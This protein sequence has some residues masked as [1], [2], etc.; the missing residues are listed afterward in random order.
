MFDA[1][2][3][4]RHGCRE[5]A[6][7]GEVMR[8]RVTLA[9]MASTLLILLNGP[10]TAHA[11]AQ[12]PVAKWSFDE[13]DGAIARESV[14]GVDDKI[15]GIFKRVSGV[16]GGAL[17]LDG[18]TTGIVQAAANAPKL[19]TAFSIESWIAINTYSWNWIPIVDQRK[20]EEAG[21]LFGIDSFGHLGLQLAANGHWQSLTSTVPIPL[22][23]WTHVAAT[24]DSG[25]GLAIYLDG[26]LAGELLAPG[27]MIS[28]SD[29]DLLIGRLREA[30]VPAQWIHPKY[31]VWY[32]FDG[33]I[34]ELEIYN[35]SLTASEIAAEY[36]AVH[37]P[38]GEILPYPILPSG[39][40]GPGS[41]GAYYA[42]LKYDE[43]WDAPRR[44][45]PDSDV[46]VRFDDSPIRLVFWQGTNYI[47]A[48]VTENGKWYSDEFMETWGAGCP[49]G[50]DC[51]PMSDKQNRYAH[52]RIIESTAARAVVHFRYG[53]CEVEHYICANIDPYTGWADWGDEYYTV[54]PDGVAVRKQVAWTSN[55]G[56][57]HGKPG[58]EFQETI[59]INPPGTR[60][61]DNIATEAL[62]LEN[63][64]GEAFTYSWAPESPATLDRPQDAN[65]QLVNLKSSWKPFQIVSP[66]NVL[67]KPYRHKEKTYSIFEWWNHWPV[68]QVISSGI[69]AVAA[70]KPSHSSLSHIEGQPYA[71]TDDSI[72]KLMLDGLTTKPAQELLPLA[73]SWIS[74][75]AMKLASGPFRTEAYDPTQRAYVAAVETGGGGG[76]FQ[77]SFAATSDSP[78]MN[79][80]I[81]I[82][83]WGDQIPRLRVNGRAVSWG[84]DFRV[85]QVHTLEGTNLVIWMKLQA[86]NLTTVELIPA[87]K[88]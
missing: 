8:P 51:E 61:E 58:H 76:K 55:F 75:P 52:V 71:K 50:A 54:Y 45:G 30:V 79:P 84:P 49:D 42:S 5:R 65:I 9:L 27:M 62:T 4:S 18:D 59:I 70:D 47:P 80:A 20:G 6:I 21:Y 12:D 13:T 46:V 38:Q 56:D 29:Q 72:T 57:Q 48:W 14:N 11:H 68:A 36:G 77:A 17:R 73:R 23:K 39:P 33:I 24:F 15:T 67:L 63:M 66:G 64:K 34:D 7:T 22:K 60:P 74:P 53:L 35:R 1:R 37:P 19:T 44:V 16:S 69:S 28:A 86:T 32:S 88:N 82:K 10:M 41:F 43:L 2:F 26:K 81:V 31:P 25:R 78:L 85:G 87:N 83:N 3:L 40:G